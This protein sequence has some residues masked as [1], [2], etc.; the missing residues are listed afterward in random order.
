MLHAMLHV[1][2]R[3]EEGSS[4]TAQIDIKEVT[5][6]LK[7][8]EL[9]D[10]IENKNKRYIINYQ[11]SEIKDS[12]LLNYLSNLELPCE[13]DLQNEDYKSKESLI[14]AYLNSKNMIEL[15]S[16][17]LNV[18]MI[19]LERRGV[20]TDQV[21]INPLFSKEE[22][23]LFINSHEDVL[24]KWEHFIESSIVYSLYILKDLDRE[25]DIKSLAPNI[26]DSNYVG[27]NI[28][29]LF[30]I[31]S[32]ME[33]FFMAPVKHEPSFFVRQ[34]EEYMFR[35]ANLYDFFLHE[36]NSMFTLLLAQYSGSIDI[37]LM[38]SAVHESR[39]LTA[40]NGDT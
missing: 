17:S 14:L 33:L 16:L 22:V 6:P 13:L 38:N 12:I 29:H 31:P 8:E 10:F 7:V 30:K 35:G 9:K 21:F 19:L 37:N 11:K 28:V 23:K 25:N 5:A 36:N 18:A 2:V 15:S 4:M 3:E 34:F 40:Q 32:F 26:D 24:N 39:S 1:T 20:V 27:L